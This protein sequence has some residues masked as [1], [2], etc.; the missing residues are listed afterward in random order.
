MRTRI[1][2]VVCALV[3]AIVG[4]SIAAPIGNAQA[5]RLQ[6]SDY[7]KLRAVGQVKF[8]PDGK[9]LAYTITRFD[10][11]GRPWSQ[12]WV[13]DLATKKS[14]RMGG[15]DEGSGGPVW[16][17]D[18]K[19]IAYSGMAEG[20]QGLVMAHPDGTGATYLAEVTGTNAPL[21][22]QGASVTWSPDS[23]QIAFIS[24]TPGPETADASG[25]PMVITRY[26][27]KPD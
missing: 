10:R 18:G 11:P 26:M 27:Y 17:P 19:W 22:S 12:V 5:D 24:A 25:D 23:K 6:P 14:V 4:A 2:F 9:L 3:I 21:P 15:E 20:K 16:S 13:M 7:Q 1:V 8:S